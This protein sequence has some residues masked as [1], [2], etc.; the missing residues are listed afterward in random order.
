MI[1]RM[2]RR[3]GP[4][5]ELAH[6]HPLYGLYRGMLQRCY[7]PKHNRYHRYGGRGVTVCE[8]WL[9]PR[10]G[11][12]NFVEDMGPRPEG[13]SLDRWPDPDGNYEPTNTR[14]ATRRQQWETSVQVIPVQQGERHGMSKLTETDVRALFVIRTKLGFNGRE[15]AKMFGV[16]EATVCDI[17]KGRSWAH[18]G[19][20]H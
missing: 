13:M 20:T 11:F 17:I 6:S 5:G 15:T 19:L 8:R 12:W 9:E 3:N 7:Y 4:N 10:T 16:S 1:P 2:Y 18:L 14:W